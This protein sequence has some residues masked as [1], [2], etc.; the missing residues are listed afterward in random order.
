MLTRRLSGQVCRHILLSVAVFGFIDW[1]LKEL[2]IKN[3]VFF[4]ASYMCSIAVFHP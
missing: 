1:S 2:K 3:L 4:G